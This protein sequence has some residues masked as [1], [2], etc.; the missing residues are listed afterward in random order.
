LDPERAGK[1]LP[2]S[3]PTDG[4]A[5]PDELKE[6]RSWMKV[7]REPYNESACSIRELATGPSII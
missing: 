4:I 6:K 2:T 7:K 3:E 5:G 1:E